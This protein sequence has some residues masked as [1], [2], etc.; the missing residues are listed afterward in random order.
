[1]I[2]DCHVNGDARNTNWL[3]K[4]QKLFVLGNFTNAQSTVAVDDE[5]S[6]PGIECDNTFAACA[7]QCAMCTLSCSPSLTGE[8][9]HFVP[10]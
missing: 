2:A 7:R 8:P 9:G 4:L 3:N 10:G 1:M 6:R 5:V